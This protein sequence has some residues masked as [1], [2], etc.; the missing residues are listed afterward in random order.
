MEQR[1][2]AAAG[3]TRKCH[4]GPLICEQIIE[5]GKQP[6]TQANLAQDAKAKAEAERNNA[7]AELARLKNENQQLKKR[8][9]TMTDKAQVEVDARKQ[10]REDLLLG[11]ARLRE[12]RDLSLTSVQ[13]SQHGN[14]ASKERMQVHSE[15]ENEEF[16]YEFTEPQSPLAEDIKH[17][18][19]EGL[20]AQDEESGVERDEG[21][22]DAGP[23]PGIQD[24][25]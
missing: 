4:L 1:L 15:S 12:G 24:G 11:R 17:T 25:P 14:A 16:A 3:P 23:L 18:H 8:V 5:T 13:K 20:H 2:A 22:P 19:E 9:I 7:L 6:K 21:I 10:Q